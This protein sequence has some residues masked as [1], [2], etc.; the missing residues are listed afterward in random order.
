[1]RPSVSTLRERAAAVGV[2]AH[3]RTHPVAAGQHRLTRPEEILLPLELRVSVKYVPLPSH[4]PLALRPPPEKWVRRA[5][6]TTL[7]GQATRC[8][9][10]WTVRVTVPPQSVRDPIPEMEFPDVVGVPAPRLHAKT[11]G[12]MV[13]L[14]AQAVPAAAA[15]TS[16]TPAVRIP[17]V[18]IRAR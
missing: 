11:R 3:A 1:M 18:T 6:A 15:P 13:S 4:L 8:L 14:W 17:A 9:R 10:T 2:R 12:V 5:S 7:S 16:T